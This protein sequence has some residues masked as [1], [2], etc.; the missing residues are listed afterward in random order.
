MFEKNISVKQGWEAAGASCLKSQQK[1]VPKVS[2]VRAKQHFGESNSR[3]FSALQAMLTDISGIALN[4]TCR[5]GA[6]TFFALRKAI[7]VL[8]VVLDP[9]VQFYPGGKL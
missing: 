9:I 1:F 8:L 3:V 2:K 6:N 4:F 5:F 7:S